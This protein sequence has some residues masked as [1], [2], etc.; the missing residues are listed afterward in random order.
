MN[1]NLN[2]KENAVKTTTR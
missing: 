2:T 1:P